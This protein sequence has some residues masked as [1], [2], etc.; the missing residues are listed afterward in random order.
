MVL[1]LFFYFRKDEQYFV[2]ALKEQQTI[3]WGE[4]P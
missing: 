4:A 2:I 3:A 1:R